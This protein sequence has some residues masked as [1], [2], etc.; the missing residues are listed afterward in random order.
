MKVVFHVDEL[1]MIREARHNIEHI[2]LSDS[3]L[4]VYY[5]LVFPVRF[6]QVWPFIVFTILILVNIFIH[7][8]WLRQ[9]ICEVLAGEKNK[10]GGLRLMNIQ[11]LL[12][13][14]FI[15]QMLEII[16]IHLMYLKKII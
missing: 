3:F 12:S 1:G 11:E 4:A 10:L 8:G 2:L 13:I 14:A 5:Y 6:L 9:G 15:T 7:L 16:T